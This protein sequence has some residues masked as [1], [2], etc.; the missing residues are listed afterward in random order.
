MLNKIVFS[1]IKWVP[2]RV[3]KQFLENS[4][5]VQDALINL[6]ISLKNLNTNSSKKVLNQINSNYLYQQAQKMLGDCNQNGIHK[7]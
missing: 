4:N 1:L 6:E 3:K 2:L 7:I 5:N